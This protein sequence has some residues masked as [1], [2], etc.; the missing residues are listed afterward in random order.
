VSEIGSSNGSDF[1]SEIFFMSSGFSSELS[2]ELE[3]ICSTFKDFSLFSPLLDGS[4]SEI[5]IF[6][7]YYF[8]SS[9][10]L[11]SSSSSSPWYLL[12]LKNW[13]ASLQDLQDHSQSTESFRQF[14]SQKL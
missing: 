13:R 8:I 12:L 2:H 7:S 11:S 10:S 3:S 4:I 5:D 14:S 1:T 6:S 9:T